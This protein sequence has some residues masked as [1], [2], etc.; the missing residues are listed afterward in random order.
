MSIYIILY[1]TYFFNP[2]LKFFALENITMKC[3]PIFKGVCT[4]LVTPFKNGEVDYP[5]LK[6]LIEFQIESGIDALLINGTTGESATLNEDEKQELISFAVRE[7][8]GRVPLIA[9]TGSNSTRSAIQLSKFA[10]AVGANALLVVTPYYNKASA[11]GLYKHYEAIA[12]ACDAPIFIYNVPSRTGLNIPLEI[13]E[14]LA[15]IDNIVAIKEASTSVSDLV[16]LAQRC[17][18]TLDVYSGN[19]DL[20]LPALALGGKGVISVLSNA[21]PK[22]TCDICKLWFAGNVEGARTLQLRLLPLINALFSEVNPI[23]VKA[24]LSHLGFCDEEYRLPLCQMGENNKK[25]LFEIYEE[26]KF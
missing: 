24:L 21:L 18:G 13:Y 8:D 7:V 1:F 2:I 3:K 16:R 22:E 15:K 20:I 4:A 10:H 23:P 14:R 12:D 26:F 19:D 25:T 6:G 11:D 9:G 5:S 17:G